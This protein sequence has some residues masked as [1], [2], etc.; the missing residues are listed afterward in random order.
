MN[1][2]PPELISFSSLFCFTKP[3]FIVLRLFGKAKRRGSCSVLH[4][5]LPSS[6]LVVTFR[7][8]DPSPR[9]IWCLPP[10]SCF[11]SRL[12]L[13]ALL[14]Q[15]PIDTFLSI[16]SVTRSGVRHR[17]ECR[18]RGRYVDASSRCPETSLLRVN[19]LSPF[20]R[21]IRSVTKGVR[22]HLFR[23]PSL[24]TVSCRA[25]TRRRPR[26]ST[27]GSDRT[28]GT[29]V[30]TTST[31]LDILMCIASSVERGHSHSFFRVDFQLLQL[32]S[33]GPQQPRTETRSVTG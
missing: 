3:V 25:E 4:P 28:T 29:R 7:H 22:C 12:P 21:M 5:S 2:P 23:W 19:L 1:V 11:S 20:R 10:C 15:K 9:A 24:R 6:L 18:G 30:R 13:R 8:R 17:W 31:C 32:G 16:S 27:S 26:R 33:G 14:L